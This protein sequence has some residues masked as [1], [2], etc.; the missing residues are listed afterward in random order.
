MSDA[1]VT[2]KFPFVHFLIGAFVLLTGGGGVFA[3]RRCSQAAAEADPEAIELM[4]SAA[5]G[6]TVTLDIGDAAD[7]SD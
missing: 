7:A 2:I 5:G 4:V 3:V 6:D 1:K